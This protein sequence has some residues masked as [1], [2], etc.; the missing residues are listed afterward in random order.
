MQNLGDKIVYDTMEEI[1][2]PRHTVLLLWDIIDPFIKMAFNREEFVKNLNSIV[3]SA[4]KS[5]IP[6]FFITIQVLPKRFESSVNTYT[7]GKLGFDRLFEPGF[8]GFSD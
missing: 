6:M 5:N 8:T 2:D 7:M 3:E 1:L 4:P